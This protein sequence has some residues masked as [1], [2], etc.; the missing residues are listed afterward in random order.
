L[1]LIF[2]ALMAAALA[3]EPRFLRPLDNT[4]VKA[5]PLS[6]VAAGD[7]ELRLDG[8][9]IEASH[10][11]AGVTTAKVTPAAGPHSL[12]LGSVT[13]QFWSGPAAGKPEFHAHPPDAG[14]ETCHVAKKGEWEI[15]G[16]SAGDNCMACHDRAA[17]IKT[18]Q[19]N[20]DVLQ[21][22][23]NCHLPHGSAV[24]SHLKMAKEAACKQC[25]G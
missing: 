3:E 18:H 7:G 5:G 22:C 25:H 14:C 17:F 15:K 20:P 2:L 1:I 13:I 12:T 6:I 16:G 19:H 11:A 4:A 10:P 24:K 23:Q 8:K 21:D 9:P